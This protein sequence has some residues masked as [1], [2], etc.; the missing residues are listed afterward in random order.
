MADKNRLIP[1]FS[2]TATDPADIYPL[3]D[4]I[5]EAEWKVL[6]ISQFD[7]A[8]SQKERVDMLPYRKSTWINDH[9]STM[10]EA[11]GKSRKKNL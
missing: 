10:A 1:P 7:A 9:L 5:P 6:S 4:I 11:T 8:K 3:H 2:E